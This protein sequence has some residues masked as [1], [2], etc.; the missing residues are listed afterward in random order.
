M[1]AVLQSAFVHL[2]LH[3]EYSLFES[4]AGILGIVQAAKAQGTSAVAMTDH[5]NLYG[6]IEFYKKAESEGI[7]PIFG[8]E[9]AFGSLRPKDKGAADDRLVLLAEDE[10]GY[11][12]LLE[13]VT[14][15]SSR[16]TREKLARRSRGLI[17]ILGGLGGPLAASILGD[18]PATT[19]A[20]VRFFKELFGD[21]FY[22]EVQNHGLPRQRTLNRALAE[23]GKKHGIPLVATNDV[24]Y[25]AKEDARTY[26]ALVAMAPDKSRDGRGWWP[27]LARE[28]WFKTAEEMA[29]ALG[30]FPEA[31]KNTLRIAE[32]CLVR[33]DLKANHCPSVRPLGT[34]SAQCLRELVLDG[35]QRRYGFNPRDKLF[36]GDQQEVLKRMD[37]ELKVIEDKGLADYFLIF[38]DL[39]RHATKKGIPL[40][41][42]RGAA[43]GSLVNYALGVTG[44]DP[45]RHGLLFERFLNPERDGVSMIDLDV[46][47]DRLGELVHRVWEAHREGVAHAPDFPDIGPSLALQAAGRALK[48]PKRILAHLAKTPV[49]VVLCEGQKILRVVG[50]GKVGQELVSIA[51][52]LGGLPQARVIDHAHLVIGGRFLGTFPMACEGNGKQ[53]VSH[54][55]WMSLGQLNIPMFKGVPSRSLTVIE[56]T[57]R[58]VERRQGIKVDPETFPP[59]DAATFALLR[60]GDTDG[61]AQLE[62]PGV[63]ALVRKIAPE[64]IEDVFALLGFS[65]LG[66]HHLTE[67]IRRKNGKVPVT[68]EFSQ[69]KEV[70]ANTYGLVLYEEQVMQAVHILAGDDFGQTD[71]FHRVRNR[72]NEREMF[73]QRERFIEGCHAT[74]RISRPM[75]ENLFEWVD[76][77]FLYAWPKAHVAAQGTLAYRAA[78]LKAHYPFEFSATIKSHVILTDSNPQK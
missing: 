54:Y 52:K 42:G 59:D 30:E 44:V 38:A 55:P 26:A 23:I 7:R 37:H 73:A 75:A 20:A 41:P 78:Y 3:T 64:R 29:V 68:F 50:R 6:A 33:M 13:L 47:E 12:N 25:I 62:G 69:L 48:L 76:D 31:L 66:K 71:T 72:R 28:A 67:F 32:R 60:R 4:T 45:L 51:S 11:S 46:A 16:V 2:R 35:V 27:W 43:S 49:K 1:N 10:V 17:A 40:G 36:T 77:A 56:G 53:R 24:H 9:V 19:R 18:R 14:V 8:C 39:V 65:R 61:I 21:H 22:L 57:L 63:P 34:S 70:G 5:G 74:N 15:R 58:E